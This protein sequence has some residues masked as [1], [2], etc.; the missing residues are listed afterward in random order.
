MKRLFF[1]VFLSACQPQDD[2]SA[3]IDENAIDEQAICYEIYQPV[4]GCD[5][6]TYS[7]D[8]YARAAGVR[9]FTSGSCN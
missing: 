2:N 4:C 8:C 7:N 1:I 5:E 6:Q 9:T 3:C